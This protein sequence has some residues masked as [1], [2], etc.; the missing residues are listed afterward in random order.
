MAPATR[1][2]RATACVLGLALLAGCLGPLDTLGYEDRVTNTLDTLGSTQIEDDRIEDKHPVFDPTRTVVEIVR[3]ASR[4]PI[5]MNKSATVTKLDIVPFEGDETHARGQ[6]VSR[7]Q[8]EA[9]DADRRRSTGPDA[10]PVDGGRQRLRSSRSTTACTPPMEL[11]VEDQTSGQLIAALAHAPAHAADHRDRRRAAG[12]RR[13]RRAGRHRARSWRGVTPMLDA[14]LQ[15]RR[16]PI[17]APR[18]QAVAASTR[19]RSAFTPGSPA[20]ERVFTRDRFLQN[21][22]GDEPFGALAALALVLGQDPALLRGLPARSP[23]FTRG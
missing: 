3:Q 15:A 19:G 21:R 18:S 6:A 8:A 11:A 20:L 10:D 4:C 1:R 13:R 2:L 22:G 9:L 12:V 5:T 14:S 17:A 23:R 16:A 7:A